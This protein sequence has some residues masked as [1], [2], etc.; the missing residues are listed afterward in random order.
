MPLWIVPASH[1]PAQ[2]NGWKV[3]YEN[4]VQIIPPVDS[5]ISQSILDNLEPEDEAWSYETV[6]EHPLCEDKTNNMVGYSFYR[7]VNLMKY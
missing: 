1:N 6:R 7:D 2:D 5:E 3:Y 4:A